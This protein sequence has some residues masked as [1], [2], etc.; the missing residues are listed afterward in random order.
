LDTQT[1]IYTAPDS[2]GEST[3]VTVTAASNLFGNKATATVNLVPF[4]WKGRGVHW[5]G[6]YLLLVFSLVYLLI[7]LWPPSLPTPE[8]AAKERLEA[9]KAVQQATDAVKVAELQV[10]ADGTQGNKQNTQETNATPGATRTRTQP[11]GAPANTNSEAAAASAAA[12]A[13][14]DS[15]TLSRVQEEKRQAVETLE[16]KRSIEKQVLDPYIHTLLVHRINRDID[17]LLLV[18]LAG[19]LGSFLHIARSFAEFIGNEQ[20]NSSWVWWYCLAPFIGAGL[21]LIF[22]A[23]VRGGFLAI[24]TS[25]N[26]KTSDLNPFGI[27]SLAAL[28]GMFS[29]EATTKLG[30]VFKTLFKS[31]APASKDALHPDATTSTPPAGTV[32]STGAGGTADKGTSPAKS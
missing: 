1:G 12:K 14:A 15:E 3:A 28:V 26:I 6:A 19:A 20:L 9:E 17:L 21:A 8:V 7:G 27:I 32:P 11:P 31:D 30:E 24:S 18:L 22:Y 5:L 23:A 2:I 4:P 13:K 10:A 16:R 25:A 29:K